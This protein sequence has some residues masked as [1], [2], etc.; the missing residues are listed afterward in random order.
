[1]SDGVHEIPRS[2]AAHDVHAVASADPFHGELLDAVEGAEWWAENCAAIH[3]VGAAAKLEKASVVLRR[4]KVLQHA[5][6]DRRSV[7]DFR[8]ISRLSRPEFSAAVTHVFAESVDDVTR[9]DDAASGVVSAQAVFGAL[10]AQLERYHGGAEA[11]PLPG[12]VAPARGIE[13]AAEMAAVATQAPAIP[14]TKPSIRPVGV[15][16]SFA[17]RM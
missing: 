12:V 14:L 5:D 11:W 4:Y 7:S 2:F 16:A 9:P 3:T 17:P 15:S 1:M 10:E 13:A 6:A 8:S